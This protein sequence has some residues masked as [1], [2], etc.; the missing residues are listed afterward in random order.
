MSENSEK[1]LNKLKEE[2]EVAYWL[3]C[4]LAYLNGRRI[5][6]KVVRKILNI[7]ET[8]DVNDALENLYRTY[9]F[10]LK[11]VHVYSITEAFQEQIKK[12]IEKNDAKII[13]DS[14]VSIMK[15]QKNVQ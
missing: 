2:S 7:I 14:L 10:T 8:D 3:A 5:S 6:I 11:D 1:K 15:L 13:L 9:E 12:T 4:F